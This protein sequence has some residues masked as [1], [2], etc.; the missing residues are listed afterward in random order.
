MKICN[1]GKETKCDSGVCTVCWGKERLRSFDAETYWKGKEHKKWVV[2]LSSA[3]STNKK[4]TVRE[5][6]VV[7]RNKAKAINAAKLHCVV[8]RICCHGSARLATPE[9]LGA[10][11]ETKTA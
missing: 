1:C 11:Y 2:T 9:D 10:K 6:I 5:Y 7:A 8:G 3:S 4:Q